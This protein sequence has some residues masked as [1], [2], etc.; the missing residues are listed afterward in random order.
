MAEERNGSGF[1]IIPAVDVVG[2]EA[3]RLR[4]GDFA[5][6]VAQAGDPAELVARYAATRPPLIHVV[7]LDGARSGTIRP[8][9]VARLAAEAGPTP[10]QASGGI[11]SLADAQVLLDAGAA[12]VVV[13][14]AAVAGRKAL[15]E[16]AAGLGEALVVA[17]DARAGKVAAAGWERETAL[18]P[19]E[20]AGLCAEAGVP[21]LLCTAI[22]RD[23]TLAGPDLALLERVRS[24]SG[25]PVLAAGGIRS[26]DDLD[27]LAALG[28]EGA[29]VGRALLEGA[30]TLR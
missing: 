29:V 4:Q 22:E 9:L 8:D 3:V 23:G 18:T 19:E 21:R 20:F 1:Q 11:R 12:R 15:D 16:L 7:D 17:V 25:L 26:D 14:T 27:G 28:L 24:G 30:L 10:L 6:V 13:G 2:E 5:R